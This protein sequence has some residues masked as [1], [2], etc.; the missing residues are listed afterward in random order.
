MSFNRTRYD[1]CAYSKELQE[2]TSPLEY[3]LFMGKYE[4][5]KNCPVGS[6]T[7]NLEFGSRAS[8]ESEL[9]GLTRE[10]SRCPEK[11]YNP[12]KPGEH[13]DFSPARMCESIYH[14]TP[15]NMK[16]PTSNGLNE[17]ALGTN[18]CAK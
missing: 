11:K 2:S 16:M 7:N 18:C 4:S 1:T 17:N 8:V 12:N 14:I 5:C 9:Y 13:A 6:F 10:N 15:T 3:Y